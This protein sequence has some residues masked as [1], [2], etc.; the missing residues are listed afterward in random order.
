ML[1]LASND[2]YWNKNVRLD[3]KGLTC[4]NEETPTKIRI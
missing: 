3:F 4:F 2:D 1:V